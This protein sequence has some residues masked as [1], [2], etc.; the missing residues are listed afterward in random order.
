MSARDR[1][2]AL[3]ATAGLIALAGWR[4]RTSWQRLPTAAVGRLEG[5]MEYVRWGDGP[6]GLIW[7]PGGPGSDVPR[8]A[9]A[10]LLSMQ[11]LPLLDAGFSVWQVARRRHMPP[12]HTV[13]DMA[14]DYANAIAGDF[15]GRVDVVVGLSYGEMIAH[16]LAAK[17]SDRV[18]NVVLASSAARITD[19]GQDVDTRW[20]HER[21]AGN[22]AQAGTVMAEYFF[23][24][25][26]RRAQRRAVGPLLGAAMSRDV[27]P[28]G[29]LLIEAEAEAAFDA[30]DMLP[31]I[32]I[33]VLLIA[34]EKDLFFTPEIVEETVD[35]IP[36]CTLVRL[37]GVGHVRA[38]LGNRLVQEIAAYLAAG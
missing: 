19:W 30:R 34:A 18:G 21:A 6:R 8:G 32:R 16:N 38:G 12:G 26:G 22:G 24:E 23:P 14:D 1:V 3:S 7:I 31:E 10:R 17:H 28:P 15:G 25:P 13:A 27:T 33:P 29:D 11:F 5:G 9:L 37:P 35:L 36:D 4:A 2:L 20:A